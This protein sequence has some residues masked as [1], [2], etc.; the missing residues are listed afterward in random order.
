MIQS[1]NHLSLSDIRRRLDFAPAIP[2]PLAESGNDEELMDAAVLLLLVC[3]DNRWH[4][5]YTRRTE[6]V[7]DHKGQVSFP[8]G[9]RE[10]EDASLEMTALRETREEI[11]MDPSHI[12]ILSS[13]PPVKTISSYRIHPFIGWTDWPQ[14]LH[15]AVTEVERIFLIPIDWL[16][17]ENNWNYQTFIIPGT[18][19]KR[20]TIVYKPY[21]GEVLWGITAT[22]TRTFLDQ[23]NKQPR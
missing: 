21:D 4:I 20:Q 11:G 6:N 8:G 3:S 23:I 5:L 13:L 22:M 9:A 19:T 15:P 2:A 12:Q 14:E 1:L 16:A 7:R 17:D 10:M 18:Q